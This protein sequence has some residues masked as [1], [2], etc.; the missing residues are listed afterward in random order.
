MHVNFF[1]KIKKV[2]IPFTQS[3]F[4]GPACDRRVPVSTRCEDYEFYSDEMLEGGGGDSSQG[5]V[6]CFCMGIPREDGQPTPCRGSGLYRTTVSYVSTLG[7]RA[8]NGQTVD[9]RSAE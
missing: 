1:K 6:G 8:G 9:R 7:V 2:F 4:S 5:C 3:G